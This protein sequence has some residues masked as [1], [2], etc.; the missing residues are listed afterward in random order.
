VAKGWEARQRKCATSTAGGG[1]SGL[2]WVGLRG[3]EGSLS[4]AKG[5][6]GGKLLDARFAA[7]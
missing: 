2:G 3:M 4:L 5:M 6:P 7:L 1:A